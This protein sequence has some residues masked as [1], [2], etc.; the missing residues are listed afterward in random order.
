LLPGEIPRLL[1]EPLTDSN[2]QSSVSD[3]DYAQEEVLIQEAGN[4]EDL[5]K[6]HL[7]ITL[8]LNYKAFNYRLE[9]LVACQHLKQV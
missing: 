6:G 8:V 7:N 9:R 3:V 5:L 1:E 4:T 2:S